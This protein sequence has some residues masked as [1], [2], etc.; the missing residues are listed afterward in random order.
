MTKLQIVLIL[1]LSFLTAQN[2]LASNATKDSTFSFNTF[3][4][5]QLKNQWLNSGN[6]AGLTFNANQNIAEVFGEYKLADGNFRRVREASHLENYSL[7]AESYL[8]I[9]NTYFYGKLSYQ[10][11]DETG[12]LY[13][14][15][16][17]PYRGNPYLI[18]DSVP[19]ANFHKEGFNLSGGV[20]KKLTNQLSFGLL[21]DYHIGKSA[22][23]KDPRPRTVVTDLLLQPSIIM[24][25]PNSNLG[26]NLGYRN[27][28]EDI[29]YK[30]VVTDD[31]DPTYFM[32]KGMGF[33]SSETGQTK[34]RYFN[35][36]SISAGV[37]FDTKLFD[38]SSLTEIRGTYSKEQ[39]EDGTNTIKK[40]DAGDWKTFQ[41]ELNQQFTKHT[42]TS[43]QKIIF[44]T[45]FF[46][47]DGIEYIQDAILNDDNQ[48]EY[49]TLSKNL[50]LNRKE[51]DAGVRFD[52]LKLDDHEQIKWETTLQARYKLKT[53]KYYYIPEI[54][55]ANYSNLE[56]GVKFVKDFYFRKFCLVPGIGL[57]Y[58]YNLDQEL[59]LSNDE[60]ITRRQNKQLYIHDFEYHTADYL[61]VS[62]Q[63]YCGYKLPKSENID[64]LFLKIRYEFR[65]VIDSN[66]NMGILTAKL[67]FIF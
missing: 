6:I 58:R 3:K 45:S 43:I 22:K 1:A 64:E 57:D 14:G 28:K 18:G 39:T 61:I 67:G 40:D 25:F 20:A 60:T 10:Y 59:N 26:F 47:G 29:E 12:N 62:P 56:L 48:T 31:P 35:Q 11:S 63:V 44:R 24:H 49:I 37:Q 17:N 15:L 23:Q 13:N 8:T 30:Q 55:N 54:F 51:F 32:F 5:F 52:Y 33:Y 27:R 19:G 50:K 42:E 34:S 46:D 41:V 21:A 65:E 9:N 66:E 7:S 53:E 38:F 36:N 16:F 2:G 4:L